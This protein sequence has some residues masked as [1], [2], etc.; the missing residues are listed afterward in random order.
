MPTSSKAPP[1]PD[2][3]P[4]RPVTTPAREIPPEDWK[5]VEYSF[6]CFM[7]FSIAVSLMRFNLTKWKSL[8]VLASRSILSI[9]KF[10]SYLAKWAGS[11]LQEVVILLLA[12]YHERADDDLTNPIFSFS[13]KE[14][15]ICSALRCS[16]F[17]DNCV[18]RAYGTLW[19]ASEGKPFLSAFCEQKMGRIVF[20]GYTRI[21]TGLNKA[22]ENDW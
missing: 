19:T 18:T 11:V 17:E 4:D 21:D 14:S 15:N 20:I 2:I 16:K 10:G 3:W 5:E 6:S 22:W 7:L 13:C 1:Q 12:N 9:L 8:M